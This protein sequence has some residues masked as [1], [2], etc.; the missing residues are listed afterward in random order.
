V[1]EGDS[2]TLHS[3]FTN[4]QITDTILWMFGPQEILIAEILRIHVFVFG[5]SNGTFIER[6]MLDSQIGDLT[7]KNTSTEISGVYKLQ[8]INTSLTCWSFNVTFIGE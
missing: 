4:I 3:N 8:I 2:V 5:Y 1:K 7:I 6:L